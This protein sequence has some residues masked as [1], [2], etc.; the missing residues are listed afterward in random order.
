MCSLRANG[1]LFFFIFIFILL[2]FFH[3]VLTEDENP[4]FCY[5]HGEQKQM[6]NWF[7]FFFFFYHQ[8][9]FTPNNLHYIP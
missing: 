8:S 1:N 3:Y 6:I 9:Y 7:F 5:I 2:L 4:V